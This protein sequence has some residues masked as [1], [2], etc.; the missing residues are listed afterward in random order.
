MVAISIWHNLASDSVRERNLGENTQLRKAWRAS[1][2]R[3]DAADET[4]RAKL[5]FER[6][7]LYTL[8]IDFV[9]RLYGGRLGGTIYGSQYL[10]AD[11]F[12]LDYLEY[13]ERFLEFLVDLESQL[14]TRRYVN[15]MLK[16]LNLLSLIRLSPLFSHPDNGLLRDLYILFRHFLFFSIED[17]TG[18][19]YTREEAYELHCKDLARL[20]RVALK[21]FKEKLTILALSNYSSIDQRDELKSHLQLLSDKELEDLS[22]TLGFR[23]HYPP[24]SGVKPGRELSMDVLL[25]AFERKKTF[26]ETVIL[27]SVLPTEAAIYEESLLRNEAYDGSKPLALP[28]INLQ[29]LAAGDFL[30]RA[31]ILHR[32]EQFFEIKKHLEEVIK[33][34]QPTLSGSSSDLTFQG[35]SRMALPISKPAILEVAPAKVGENQPAYVRAEV[36]LNLGRLA[37]HVRRDWDSLRPEDTVFLLSVS[38]TNNPQGLTNG[39]T[40]LQNV[41]ESG[42]S[43]LRVAEVV[44]LLEENGRPVREAASDQPNGYGP[45]PR[46]RRLIVNLDT[47]AYLTDIERKEKGMVDVYEHMNIIV[48][49]NKRENNFKKILETIR[50]LA[51]SKVPIP[52]WLQEVFLG[53]GDPASATYT[54]LP[55]RIKAIDMRDTLIDWQH[56]VESLP[57]KVKSSRFQ[58][59]LH[60]DSVCRSLS[61]V[62]NG[63]RASGLPTCSKILLPTQDLLP[64]LLGS[65]EETRLS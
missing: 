38:P 59:P 11:I 39:H 63:R 30:W 4:G 23:T 1:A 33:K 8:L 24:E 45:R 5:R 61:P 14:P 57:G 56:L 28:K 27:M 34:L 62:P 64:G 29:Y 53:F 19:Q 46:L 16:D 41:R 22:S 7:W 18:A 3:Y 25:S 31:F 35:F 32:C 2:K 60:T 55:N 58:C 6:S 42:L 44:Q 26:Q 9:G 47:Q 65:E 50:S 54:N 12:E 15:T 36:T 10:V 20:Q 13:C 17:Y 21:T 40:G 43:I 49:R 51:T 52:D 37:D 48:R